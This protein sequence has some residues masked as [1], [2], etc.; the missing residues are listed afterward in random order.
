MR[1]NNIGL[2]MIVLV[3]CWFG[4]GGYPADALPVDTA[5]PIVI[6]RVQQYLSEETPF[7]P[8]QAQVQQI[9]AVTWNNACL[10]LAQPGEL[11]AQMLTPGYEI[12]VTTPKGMMDLHTNQQATLIRPEPR[13]MEDVPVNIPAPPPLG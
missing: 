4:F 1:R 5:P 3:L 11:C 12:T 13:T 8:A 6:E 9:E 2:V 7:S 10:E